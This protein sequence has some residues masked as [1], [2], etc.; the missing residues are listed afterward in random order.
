MRLVSY[1]Q[2][3]TQYK[4]QSEI[5]MNSSIYQNF[6]SSK[7][8]VNR[9]TTNFS[10]DLFKL[11]DNEGVDAIQD[12][13]IREDMLFNDVNTYEEDQKYVLPSRNHVE[14]RYTYNYSLEF[15]DPKN[16]PNEDDSYPEENFDL[17]INEH[18]DE[19]L[20]RS[21]NIHPLNSDSILKTQSYRE[22]NKSF[23]IPA[24]D[25]EVINEADDTIISPK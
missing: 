8:L 11:R 9:S 23:A 6:P 19:I 21:V 15:E 25:L 13:K 3:R 12:D 16:I 2:R 22:Q 1:A 14:G 18:D 24:L 10:S 5:S 7:L 17:N 20:L 4:Q